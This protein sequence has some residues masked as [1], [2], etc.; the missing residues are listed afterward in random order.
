MP[1]SDLIALIKWI[2]YL[3]V[4]LHIHI[5]VGVLISYLI[6]WIILFI[7]FFPNFNRKT[8]VTYHY[9]VI[10]LFKLL[11]RLGLLCTQIWT[12]IVLYTPIFVTDLLATS[13]AEWPSIK[14]L[15]NQI[16]IKFRLRWRHLLGKLS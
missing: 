16:G 11:S 3:T 13:Y 5:W 7:V 8:A 2:G 9:F 12:Q 4:K 15:A 14:R 10:F 1:R 6:L